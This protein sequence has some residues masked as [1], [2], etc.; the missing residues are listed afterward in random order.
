MRTKH[1]VQGSG[2]IVFQMESVDVLLVENVLW[3]LGVC[4]QPQRLRRRA[5]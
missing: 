4:S 1:V 2:A 3:V 5:M